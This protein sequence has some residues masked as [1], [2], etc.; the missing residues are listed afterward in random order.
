MAAVAAAAV[1]AAVAAA[2]AVR[3]LLRQANID[4]A[5]CGLPARTA[6]PKTNPRLTR[7]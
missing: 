7:T 2:A 1:A 5:A 3:R 6:L 4:R